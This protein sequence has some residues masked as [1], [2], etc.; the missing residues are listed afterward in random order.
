M[1]DYKKYF[2]ANQQLWDARVQPHLGS[3]MYDMESF[4]KGRS[5]LMEIETET[6]GDITGQD[7]LH[8]QCHFG[9][10]SLSFSRLGAGKVVGVDISKKAIDT[11]KGLALELGLDT[12]FICS[13]VYDIGKVGEFDMVF[14]TYGATPW[15]PDLDKWAQII[16]DNLKSGG[17]FY[18]C[19]FHPSIYMM[20]FD[21]KEINYDYFSNQDPIE[22]IAEG[23]YA[24]EE[25]AIN[26]KEYSWNH[27][28]S[29]I[30]TPLL[31]EGLQLS[32]I[33]E[34]DWSPYDCF[35]NMLKVG[36]NKYRM[37]LNI[38]FPHILEMVF[39]KP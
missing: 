3:K 4:R 24:D 10:D 21:T 17:I 14:S 1:K 31:N 28:T 11:A 6:L 25:A 30:I 20:D 16:S 13:N 22:E 23:T 15:L 33:Q 32:K 29:E 19:E 9:Q 35:P 37:D 2:D 26:L 5:S 8:L 38:R 12:E 34:Y 36:E 39:K 7:I 27:G 18:F